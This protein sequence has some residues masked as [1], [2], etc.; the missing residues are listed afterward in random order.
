MGWPCF[1]IEPA[2]TCALGLR[3]YTPLAGQQGEHAWTCAAGWHTAFAWRGLTAP[4]RLT[5]PDEHGYRHQAAAAHVGHADPLWPS[6][7][8]AGCGYAF[9]DGDVWQ[10]WEE[11]LYRRADTGQV[12]FLHSGWPPTPD[13]PGA[14]TAGPG[15]MWDGWWLPQSWKGSDGIGLTVRC[16]RPD[17]S[18]GSGNDWIVDAPST[19]TGGRW[20]RT[21]DPR[22]PES[23]TV[24]PSIAIGVSG[25]PGFYHG[26][27]QAGVL[28][29]HLGG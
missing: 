18:P 22:Q 16:P 5:A 12:V 28:T 19:G 25:T 21:G 1:W 7:C 17:S 14:A 13:P 24:S 27:L 8:A 2:G 23:L 9:G 4:V 26:F 15:A 10:E 20:A 3:R 29:D 6:Q 11:S